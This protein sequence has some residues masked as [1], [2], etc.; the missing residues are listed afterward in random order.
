MTGADLSFKWGKQYSLAHSAPASFGAADNS[1]LLYRW[2]LSEEEI[3]ELNDMGA[4][5]Y[6][7]AHKKHDLVW[8]KTKS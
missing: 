3:L 6:V 5:T 7:L 2:V 8:Q 1:Q 4:Q